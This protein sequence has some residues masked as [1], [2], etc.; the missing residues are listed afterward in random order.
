MP[1]F[2]ELGI[3]LGTAN[4]LV[5]VRGRG[6]VLQEPSVVAQELETGEVVAV[7]EEA[8][9]MMG[10]APE[11]IVVRRPLRAGVIADYR[12]TQRMLFYFIT[13]PS[14][15]EMHADPRARMSDMTVEPESASTIDQLETLAEL[16]E[17]GV[18]SDDEFSSAKK[19]L[20]DA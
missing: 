10:R 9:A 8:R 4:I 7:G 11:T 16:R 2:E 20:L 6:I 14:E 13:R 3:D 19:K 5:Y 15:P 17:S 12:V 18:L 1:V